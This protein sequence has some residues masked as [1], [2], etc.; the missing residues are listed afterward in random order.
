M[1]QPSLGDDLPPDADAVGLVD[2]EVVGE[3]RHP[4]VHVGAAQ[5]LVA[6]FLA[7][8]HLDQR[9]AAEEHL[10]L[11]VDQHR[12]VAHA[13]HV[14]AARG[15]VA[16]HEGDRGDAQRR[17]LRQVAEDRARRDEDIGLRRQV[18]AAGLHQVDDRQP[19]VPGDVERAQVLPQRVR[20]RRAAPHGR[21]VGD[22]DAFDAGHDA[23][24]GDDARAHGELG[25]PRR[26]RGQLEQRRVPVDEQLDPLPGEQ[27]AAG[28]VPLG[29]P[30]AAARARELQLL[31][32]RRDRGQVRVAVGA[33]RLA[34]GVH[35]G[36]E[37]GHAA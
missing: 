10:G 27:P 30:L 12:V 23:D 36:S 25:A 34:R 24:A 14:G 32:E 2:G 37:D 11:L 21:V 7:G 35:R 18:G 28:P 22:D 15:R 6:G 33:E 1:R 31:V 16:E 4:R 9:R 20:V 19:V 29:V 26:Q 5:L 8:R 13:R 17:Q 3:P